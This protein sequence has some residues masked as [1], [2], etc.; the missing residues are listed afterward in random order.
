MNLQ[1]EIIKELSNQM[2][3]TIDFEVLTEILVK[4]CGWY[5]VE[6][7]SLMNRKRSIDILEWCELNC[8]NSWKN[9]GRNFVFEDQGDAVNFTLRWR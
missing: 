3:K 9:F 5:K 1:E 6:L 4:E 8:N 7:P 2:S